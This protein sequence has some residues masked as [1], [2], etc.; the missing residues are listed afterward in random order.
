MSENGIEFDKLIENRI[1]HSSYDHNIASF[2][3]SPN[4]KKAPT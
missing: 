3:I 2:V 4:E 1:H